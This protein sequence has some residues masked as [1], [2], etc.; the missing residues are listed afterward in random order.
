MQAQQTYYAYLPANADYLKTDAALV[1]PMKIAQVAPLFES[2]PPKNYGGTERVVSYLTEELVSLGHEVTLFAT[3]DSCTGARLIPVTARNLRTE[4]LNPTGLAWHTIEFGMLGAM[5]HE[6]DV[7]HF[8]TD[9]LHFPMA[10]QLDVAHVTTLHGRLDLPGLAQLFQHF[11]DLPQVSI[12]NNQRAPL[13]CAR[14]QATVY[15]GL[16]EALYTFRQ[17]PGEYCLFLGRMSPEKRPD[18]AIEIALRAG[19]PIV[20]A[21]KVDKVDEAYFEACIKPLLLHPLVD[22]IGEVGEAEKSTLLGNARALLFPI[23]WPE[24]FGLVMI[25]AFACGTPVIAYNHGAV[26]EILTD[27]VTG[28]VV[29]DQE[30][31]LSALQRVDSIDRSNCRAAFM[32]RFSA[33]R[34]A[35]AYLDVYRDLQAPVQPV[36]QIRVATGTPVA[37]LLIGDNHG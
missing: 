20:L 28:F 19:M 8:H 10:R 27:G 7:L 21:A 11:D 9:Y 22:F 26:P 25:E 4:A 23:D 13:P 15:H 31:A 24:P 34:M 2:V 33:K 30:Q 1:N 18:R 32:Q 17:E 12:S 29:D 3:A 14:W 5:A 35:Q 36:A 16:P 6:F 37:N